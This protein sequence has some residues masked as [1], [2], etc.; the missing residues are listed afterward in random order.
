MLNYYNKKIVIFLMGPTASGKSELAM[1]LRNY[2]PIELISVDSALIY[3][4]MDIGTSKPT[5]IDLLNH[6]HRLINLIDPGDLYSVSDF[7]NDVMLEIKKIFNMN[8]IP[9]LVGGTM[10]YYY[11]LLYGISILPKSNLN[12]R[13]KL[14]Y[15]NKKKNDNFLYRYLSLIDHD[16]SKKIHPND[17][18]RII[19]ALEVYLITGKKMS[20]L[21]KSILNI[22]PYQTIQ[23]A[24][25]PKKKYLYNNIKNRFYSMLHQG[26]E[27][28]VKKL[29]YR[30][31][32]NMK[33]P[34]IRCIGYRQMWMYFL[35]DI[36]YDEMIK[37]SIQSTYN[38][39]KKQITWL[40]TWKNI[41]LLFD[42]NIKIL[43]KK[44]LKIIYLF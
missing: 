11:I 9:L 26:F 35:N 32:L 41:N 22:F 18:Q 21:K 31:D 1:I 42:T 4:N 2:F 29:F 3:K 25:I 34:S 6:P 23:F 44:I 37:L 27:L 7:R 43:I 38:F 36:S 19:R 10:F 24:I 5:G 40:K 30:G 20:F 33:L 14:L 39:S 16:S 12:L 17:I 13:R 28:E 15:Y 8:K